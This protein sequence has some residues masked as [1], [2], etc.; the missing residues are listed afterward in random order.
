VLDFGDFERAFLRLQEE[1]VL[2]QDFH[3]LVEYFAVFCHVL[4]EDQYV[5]VHHCLEGCWRVGESEEHYAGFVQSA[6]GFKGCLPFIP[7]F[8]PYIVI[9]P[10]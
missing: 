5:F 2:F 1:V 9:S 6:V 8:D 3:D 7:L 10:S 4:R